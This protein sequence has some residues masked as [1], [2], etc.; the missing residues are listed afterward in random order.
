MDRVFQGNRNK[1]ERLQCCKE[2]VTE[3]V[4]LV[5][6]ILYLPNYTAGWLRAGIA[7]GNCFV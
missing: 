5:F 3:R 2:Q 1:A 4:F 6:V 7:R